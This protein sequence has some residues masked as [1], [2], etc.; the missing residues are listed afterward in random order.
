MGSVGALGP[1]GKRVQILYKITVE[2]HCSAVTTLYY[3]KVQCI[4][5]HCTAQ[6]CSELH[7]SSLQCSAVQC[8]AVQC[9]VVQCSHCPC[10]RFIFDHL[11]PPNYPHKTL[12]FWPSVQY[13]GYTTHYSGEQCSAILLSAVLCTTV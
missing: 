6:H 2:S 4:A 11:I 7:F 12:G 9:N 5:L 1:P 10:F 13:K 8:S 3:S